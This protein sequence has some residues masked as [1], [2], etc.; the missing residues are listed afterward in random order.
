MITNATLS[1]QKLKLF[2]EDDTSFTSIDIPELI[3]LDNT[4][5]TLL[6]AISVNNSN[7]KSIDLHNMEQ[8]PF[9][10]GGENLQ[11]VNLAR[12]SSVE[13]ANNPYLGGN[14]G[15]NFVSSILQGTKIQELILPN[16][17]GTP[18]PYATDLGHGFARY[19]PFW[20]NYW[21]R[22]VELGNEF[23]SYNASYWFNGL[24]FY[25]NYFLTTL[26][27]RYP[28]QIDLKTRGGFNTTPIGAG[29]GKIYVPTNLVDTYRNAT[30]WS[31]YRNNILSIDEYAE[32]ANQDTITDSWDTIVSNCNSSQYEQ[33]N[34]GDTKTL[35]INGMPTQMVIVDKTSSSSSGLGGDTIASGT[36][37]G[38]KAALVWM[39]KTIAR[40]NTNTISHAF[41]TNNKQY[42]DATSYRNIFN[43]L[44]NGIEEPALKAENGIKTVNKTAR[45]YNNENQ[46]FSA[47]SID[48]LWPPSLAELGMLQSTPY[49]YYRTNNPYYTLGET[50]LINDGTN[51]ITI[52]LRDYGNSTNN[53]PITLQQKTNPASGEKP[54]GENTSLSTAYT[55]FGFCT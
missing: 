24:W 41:S 46:S 43:I 22:H 23:M 25:N 42:S 52:G 14:Y 33:Y 30:H 51:N 9:I 38:Q 50:T 3:R 2:F 48:V 4:G 32:S 47:S 36:Y 34:I 35:K 27:L 10:L 17:I 39:E 12:L 18:G 55:V 15:G 29:L 37:A 16:F 1:L 6:N 40:F 21:L 20:N 8:S 7:I 45:G 26:I 54:M 53:Y 11:E 13:F 44:Y 31:A 19:T 5:N 49:T 28:F